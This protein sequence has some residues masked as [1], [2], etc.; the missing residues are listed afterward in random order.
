MTNVILWCCC[1]GQSYGRQTTS[2]S[3]SLRDIE[4]LPQEEPVHNITYMN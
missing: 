2:V 4:M 3:V 1:V